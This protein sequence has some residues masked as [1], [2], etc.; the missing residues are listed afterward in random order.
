MTGTKAALKPA[1]FACDTFLGEKI[2]NLLLPKCYRLARYAP[3]YHAMF[4]IVSFF[5]NQVRYVYWKF[6]MHCFSL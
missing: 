6:L 4:L 3:L 5:L 1:Q 2:Q